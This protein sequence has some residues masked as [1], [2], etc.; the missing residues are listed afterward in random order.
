MVLILS[1]TDQEDIGERLY[2]ACKKKGAEVTLVSVS[3]RD[4]K[5]CYA[6]RGC[7]T[8]TF[9]KCVV[10]DDMD[11]ILPVFARADTLVLCFPLTWG[12]LSFDM[13]KV[14]DKSCLLGNTF[15]KVK[16]GEIVK[17]M[18]TNLATLVSVAVKD[19]ASEEEK[20]AYKALLFEI[21]NIMDLS[22]KTHLVGT[23]T[24]AETIEYL[25]K[26]VVSL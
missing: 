18:I 8:K 15:Y 7:T 21:G 14:L 24:G 6:C 11:E 10:R 5:P 13:K 25:A 17:G 4:V 20:N 1:D 22:L 26:E 19:H 12:G 9:G 2:Q 3:G 16:H 23:K